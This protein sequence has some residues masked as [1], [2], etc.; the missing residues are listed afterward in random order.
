MFCIEI[1]LALSNTLS[2]ENWKYEV[3]RLHLQLFAKK[4]SSNYRNLKK[5][6][7]FF[8][9]RWKDDECTWEISPGFVLLLSSP[10]STIPRDGYYLLWKTIHFPWKKRRCKQ[11][12]DT[13]PSLSNT[14][15][16]VFKIVD[17][18]SSS[19]LLVSAKD[20]LSSNWFNTCIETFVF[21]HP[22]T[23][24]QII[25]INQTWNLS[26]VAPVHYAAIPI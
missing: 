11:N 9:N 10:L 8:E 13:C 7:S 16:V 22:L 26:Q 18:T 19:F 6:S 4:E 25:T 1:T 12:F 14:N 21:T 2:F 5:A 15:Y 20:A 24:T 3:K 17:H 23:I